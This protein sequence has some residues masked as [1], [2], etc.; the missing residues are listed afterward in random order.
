MN[1]T[2]SVTIPTE[3]WNEYQNAVTMVGWVF[4]AEGQD[5][6]PTTTPDDDETTQVTTTL[7]DI[8]DEDIPLDAL[9]KIGSRVLYIT[10]V[11]IILEILVSGLIL[12]KRIEKKYV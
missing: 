7:I 8:I 2:V 12:I 11:S 5:E 3:L 6:Q 10:E 1:L 9:P 4:L